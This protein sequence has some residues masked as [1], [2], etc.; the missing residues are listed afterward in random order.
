MSI[1]ISTTNSKLGLIPSVNM[2]PIL[3]CRP[4]C[5][6]A[7]DCYA[8]KGRFRFPNVVANM[9]NNYEEYIRDPDDYFEQVKKAIN[10]GMIS[11]SYFRWHA[12]GDIVDEAYFVGMVEV[13]KELPR[14]SFL[15][16]TKK[17]EIVNEYVKQRGALPHNLHIVFSAWGND[18]EVTNP[19]HFPVAYVRFHDK[20]NS[21]VPDDALE[22]SGDCTKCLQ[23][24]N[25]RRGQSVVFNKH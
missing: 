6:C 19:Y 11:Y 2:V 7:A 3:T 22:C 8:R 16:F 18:F 5:P 1:K 15:A 25:I 4:N 12:A 10:N 21:N 20:D 9:R 17:F 13:A 14:T 23:C 24:W